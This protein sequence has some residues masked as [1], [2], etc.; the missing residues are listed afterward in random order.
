VPNPL[1]E[2]EEYYNEAFGGK[3]IIWQTKKNVSL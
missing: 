3:D 1:K 2:A